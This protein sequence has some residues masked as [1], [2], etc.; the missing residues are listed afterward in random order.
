[1]PG[2]LICVRVK[3][4]AAPLPKP[5]QEKRSFY[6]QLRSWLSAHIAEVVASKSVAMEDDESSSFVI[7]LIEN[8]AKE[9]PP[10]SSTLICFPEKICRN[11]NTKLR[12]YAQTHGCSVI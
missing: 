4:T 6:K 2:F 7:G 3:E 12:F 1:M 5:R 8:R 11:L 10:L 9:V